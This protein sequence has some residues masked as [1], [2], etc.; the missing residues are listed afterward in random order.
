[1]KRKILSIVT[2][3]CIVFSFCSCEKESISPV[4]PI[5]THSDIVVTTEQPTPTIQNEHSTKKAEQTQQTNTVEQVTDKRECS[6]TV[7]CTSVFSNIDK[8]TPEKL[9][10]IPSDGIIFYGENIIF[11]ENESV[12]NVLSREL[13]KNKVHIDFVN[14][15][16]YNTIYIKGIGNLYEHD[17][18]NLSGW[19]YRVNGEVPA[20][21]CSDYILKDGDNIEFLY[22]CDL[23][24]DIT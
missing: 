7:K 3:F 10:L 14:T 17:A 5:E 13:K 19:I 21:G 12:F 6:L 9:S 16:M 1:M 11:Y 20:Y 23:G 2:V 8:L 15:P 24:K 18:G 4:T 22:T